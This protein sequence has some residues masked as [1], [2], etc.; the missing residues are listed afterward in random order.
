MYSVV[1]AMTTA[2]H[3]THDRAY[4]GGGPDARSVNGRVIY[5]AYRVL[6]VALSRNFVGKRSGNF[7]GRKKKKKFVC[8]FGIT[9]IIG[10]NC[11]HLYN[12]CGMHDVYVTRHLRSCS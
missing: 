4:S 9:H 10:E 11:R 8:R 7:V 1:T 2:L 5:D 12:A 3:L 6:Q